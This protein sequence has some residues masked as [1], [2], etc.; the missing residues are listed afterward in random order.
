MNTFPAAIIR[1]TIEKERKNIAMKKKHVFDS[2]DCSLFSSILFHFIFINA[3][4]DL[5]C[6][7][8][9]LF[10]CMCFILL[11][12]MFCV[13]NSL[14][15]TEQIFLAHYPP[16]TFKLAFKTTTTL[17]FAAVISFDTFIC[18]LFVSFLFFGFVS[19]HFTF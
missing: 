6:V 5:I 15:F 2:I 9:C 16:I 3:L 18:F 8:L 17:F 13:L 4:F 7:C 12:P 11:M 10:V 14:N 19:F 1:Y